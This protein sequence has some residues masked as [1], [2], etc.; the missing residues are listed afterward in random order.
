MSMPYNVFRHQ[1]AS[2]SRSFQIKSQHMSQKS[3]YVNFN[4]SISLNVK[5]IAPTNKNKAPDITIVINLQA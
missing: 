1:D 3:L 2:K 5:H 4:D